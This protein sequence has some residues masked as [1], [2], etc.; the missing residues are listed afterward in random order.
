[1]PLLLIYSFKLRSA[2]AD[3]ALSHLIHLVCAHTAKHVCPTLNFISP[4]TINL[5]I[6]P[7][8]LN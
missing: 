2:L 7:K 6:Q 1:M 3:H 4:V 5:E 8:P